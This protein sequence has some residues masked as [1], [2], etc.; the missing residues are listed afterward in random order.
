MP[1]LK[2]LELPDA[3]DIECFSDICNNFPNLELMR[4]DFETD[5]D[6]LVSLETILNGLPKLNEL[7]LIHSYNLFLGTTYPN[8]KI[9]VLWHNDDEYEDQPAAVLSADFF[10]ALPNLEEIRVEKL[11][12]DVETFKAL[13][14]SKIKKINV[15]VPMTTMSALSNIERLMELKNELEKKG[16]QECKIKLI[17]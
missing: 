16:L 2:K 12:G 6:T 10:R 17:P 15:R 3:M 5:D 7:A 14:A 13:L 4:V 8:L 9:L 11:V 1:S